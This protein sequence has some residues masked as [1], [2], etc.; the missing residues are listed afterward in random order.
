LKNHVYAQKSFG[1]INIVGFYV[2]RKFIDVALEDILLF[3]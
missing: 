3:L 2:A 1:R